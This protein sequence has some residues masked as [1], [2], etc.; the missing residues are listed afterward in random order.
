MKNMWYIY[1]MK[2]Y[3]TVEQNDIMKVVGTSMN[4][5]NITLSDITQI[6]KLK[7]FIYSLNVDISC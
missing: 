4:L 3:S 5:E 1:K 7:F 6:Q 2:Y